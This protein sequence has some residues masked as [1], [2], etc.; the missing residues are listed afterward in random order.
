ML[1]ILF[2]TSFLLTFIKVQAQSSFYELIPLGKFGVAY[3]DTVIY[4]NDYNYSQYGYVGPTP[5][6]VKIWYPSKS[7]QNVNNLSYGD[8]ENVKPPSS[9]QLVHQN[10]QNNINESIIRDVLT[11][12]L[13]TGDDIDYSPK[14]I[15]DALSAI[16]KIKTKAV[17]SK[18]PKKFN[19]PVIV[20]HHGSR[21]T[22]AENHLMAEYFASRGFVFIST[23]FHLPYPNSLFGLLPYELEKQNKH[24]QF[25]AKRLIL[26]AKS[27]S[28]NQKVFYVGHSYGAQEG[29]CFLHEK[30]WADAFV[31]METTIEF[32]ND[33]LKIKDM[34][35]YVYDALKVRKNRFNIPILL[36]AS[37]EVDKTFWFFDGLSS[38]KTWHV[39][40]KESFAHNSYTSLYLMRY[41]I[42]DEF[43]VPDALILKR[44]ID[45][46]KYHLE[47]MNDFFESVINNNNLKKEKYKELFYINE[48]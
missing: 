5:L 31:S 16:K 13:S 32:K 12:N 24:D 2:L 37:T 46:Y 47:L 6:F 43:P 18:L 34:W 25:I 33:S 22:S 23:N 1:R 10:L 19:Y 14:T 20:Y 26:L 11:E 15:E 4:A 30:T 28:P 42:K 8:I 41:F 36:F 48:N 3:S 40:T 29:W 44:Q 17:R 7:V 45:L 9:L 35:P 21:S 39:S 38:R 27:L